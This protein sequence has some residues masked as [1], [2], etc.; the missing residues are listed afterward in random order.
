VVL[1]GKAMLSRTLSAGIIA[2]VN[3]EDARD[4]QVKVVRVA[5]GL[6]HHHAHFIGY[7]VSLPSY[8]SHR[9][10]SYVTTPLLLLVMPR[11]KIQVG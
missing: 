2:N 6:S 8:T 1:S 9:T 4:L 10:L 11:G 5:V 3:T 7:L